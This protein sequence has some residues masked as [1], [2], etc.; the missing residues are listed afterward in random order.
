MSQKFSAKITGLGGYVPSRLIKNADLEVLLETS[1]EWIKQRTGI[2]QR[3]WVTDQQS[4]SDLAYEASLKAIQNA[5]IKTQ[6]ID[7]IVV[8]TSSPDTDIPGCAAFVQ[9]KLGLAGVPYFDI[10]QACSGFIYGLSIAQNFIH[11]GSYKCVLVVGAEV[12][13]KGLDK[14]P[15]GKGVT[16]LF[17]DGAG[18]VIVQRAVV[19]NKNT[20][21]HIIATKLHADG[22][23]AK[24]LWMPAPGSAFGAERVTHQMIDEGLIYPQMNGRLVFTN[25]VTKMPEVLNEVLSE[26]QIAVNEIDLH[27]FH[28][29]NLRINQKV[30]EDMNI[31]ISKAYTTIHKFGN[32]TAA[33]IPLGMYDAMK[34]GELKPGMLISMVTFGA[35]FTWGSA[36]VRF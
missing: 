18:A 23:S 10:R 20:D 29:A 3:Y 33:T 13:S 2:E 28:Q 35:G 32:T 30:C 6:E 21:A 14:T 24:E 5:Q 9:A 11:Q 12:Q 16:I 8:A 36:L 17:A 34:S 25:A 27:F 26:N 4:T 1:D 7:L 15:R 22:S 31:P 19:N